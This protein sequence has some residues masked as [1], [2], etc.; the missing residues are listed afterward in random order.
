MRKGFDFDRMSKGAFQPSHKKYHGSL[1]GTSLLGSL[2]GSV[3]GTAISTAVNETAAS[4]AGT[5]ERA[6]TEEQERAR[7]RSEYNKKMADLP[8]NCPNCGAPTCG[9]MYCEYCDSK[10]V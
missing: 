10:L 6:R 1:A 8:A 5:M 7:I 3:V 4:Y 9:K 2:L